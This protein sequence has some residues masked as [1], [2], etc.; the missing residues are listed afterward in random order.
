M[1]EY[2]FLATALPELQIGYPPDITFAMLMFA[3][4]V[5]L[6]PEDYAKSLTMRRYYDIQ[7]IRAFWRNEELDYHGCLDEVELEEA[8]LTRIGLPEYVYEFMDKYDNKAERLK[9]FHALLVAY[10]VH[11]TAKA[12][13]FLKEYLTFEREWR[14]VLTGF[15]AKKLGR[16]LAEELQFEDPYD[17]I[18]A[19]I[20]AQKDAKAYEPP[21]RYEDLKAL[22]EEH[23]SDPLQLYQALCEYQFEKIAAM[24]GI[25]MFSIG[26]ILAYLAQLIL[27]EKWMELDKKKGM[28]VV[29]A[30]VK[31]AS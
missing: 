23:G 19:Q 5:N 16:D 15:R 29:D 7:N 6:T 8:L 21:S 17:D 20:L 24:C 30:I 22:F 10:Y 4:K 12:D 3:F 27:V 25:E 28:E 31:E 2:Y 14:L 13:G 26:K 18:V 11:E 1:K 9:Y